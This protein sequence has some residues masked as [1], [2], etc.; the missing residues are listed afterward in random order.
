MPMGVVTP[1]APRAVT[2]SA[3]GALQASGTVT[4]SPSRPIVIDSGATATL[5]T[6]AG[7]MTVEGAIS[8]A[9][10][11]LMK[12]GSG[13]LVLSGSNSYTGGTIVEG[14]MLEAT[15]ADAL[16][17]GTSLIVG[18]DATSIFGIAVSGASSADSA[19]LAGPAGAG[20]PA[21][22]VPEPGT[23]V[24][25]IAAVCGA[26]TCRRGRKTAA[27]ARNGEVPDV[28]TAGKR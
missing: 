14:G 22:S 1:G 8:G 23:L 17:A 24:L 13:L 26:G 4:L 10:G 5:D 25:F 27:G 9:G 11:A 12:V 7:K 21:E 20:A 19:V 28:T 3:A 16:P 18:A 6:Q 2:F 15:A